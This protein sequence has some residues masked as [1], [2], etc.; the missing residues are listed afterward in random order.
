MK[1]YLDEDGFPKRGLTTKSEMDYLL[2]NLEPIK[3]STPLEAKDVYDVFDET[4]LPRP[5]Q[6]T[7]EIKQS[8]KI[9]ATD[10]I[11]LNP[12]FEPNEDFQGEIKLLD[13]TVV[14]YCR[15]TRLPGCLLVIAGAERS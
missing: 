5:I 7:R 13:T 11:K 14:H 8:Q 15:L 4:L 9:D 12:M 10:Q 1:W 2:K 6:R 3:D